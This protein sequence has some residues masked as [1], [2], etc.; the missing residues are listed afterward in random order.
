MKPSKTATAPTSK[1]Y[2][3]HHS[4]LPYE[5]EYAVR[6]IIE[7]EIELNGILENLRLELH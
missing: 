6:R 4:V 3:A 5:V 2:V 1:K 7:G